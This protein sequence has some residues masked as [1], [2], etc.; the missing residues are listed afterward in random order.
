MALFTTSKRA[1]GLLSAALF[2][3]LFLGL[4]HPSTPSPAEPSLTGGLFGLEDPPEQ[5]S[6]PGPTPAS[7]SLANSKSSD[8]LPD[9]LHATGRILADERIL[10]QGR[11]SYPRLTRLL[12]GSIL[13]AF[14][15]FEAQT[16]ILTVE[17]SVDNGRTFK[18]W[19]EITRCDGD[20]GNLFLLELPASKIKEPHQPPR[21][22]AAFRNHDVVDPKANRHITYFRITVCESLDGGRTW[23]YVAQAAEKPAPMGLWEPFMRLGAKGEVQMTYS[24]E[25]EPK[26]QDSIMRVSS[27]QGRTWSAPRTVTGGD[28]KKLRDGMTGIVATTD[29]GKPALVMVFETTRRGRTFTLEAVLSYDDG[30]TWGHR[31]V[32]FDGVPAKTNAGAPQIEAFANGGLAVVFMTDMDV[33]KRKWPWNADVKVIFG[34]PLLDGKIQWHAPEHAFPRV[35]LWPGIFKLSDTQLMVLCEHGKAI[36]GRVLEWGT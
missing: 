11:A 21:I 5:A 10:H 18:P 27:D 36:R 14:T 8:K 20:C 1:L 22:L 4:Y 3:V 17:R 35:S 12:D 26:D 2:I 16:R 34:G 30:E 19:G 24:Q 25:L 7:D 15:R 6:G 31:Q 13:L 32:V 33:E 29:R 9:V 23:A 28:E